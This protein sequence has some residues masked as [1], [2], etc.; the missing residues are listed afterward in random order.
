MYGPAN[1]IS[2][3]DANPDGSSGPEL[4]G[5]ELV[6]GSR[7][8]SPE[9]W[10]LTS[11]IFHITKDSPP[12][13]IIHGNSDTTVVRDQSIELSRVLEASGVE[14]RLILVPNAG[15]AFALKTKAFDLRKDVVEF[16][17]RH[18]KTSR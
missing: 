6:K 9:A 17:D 3:H 13:L 1:L 4:H 12:T 2:R 11:P 18:L 8:E 10:K 5:N 7:E 15:H 14:H 16:F